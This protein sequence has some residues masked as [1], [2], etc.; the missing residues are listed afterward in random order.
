MDDKK[1]HH[2]RI[3]SV[4][5]AMNPELLKDLQCFFCGGTAIALQL[6]DFRKSV[7]IDFVCS[8][9][10]GYRELRGLVGQYS[11]TGLSALFDRPVPQLREV[12]AD[13]YGIRSVLDVGGVPVKFEV[14]RE[15]RISLDASFEQLH[16]VPLIARA[17]AYAHKLLANSD[18]WGDRSVLSRDIIDLA[19]MVRSWGHVPL[20]AEQ[21]VREAYGDAPTKD[22]VLAAGRVVDDE[23]YRKNCFTKHPHK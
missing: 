2:H 7:D 4:L 15:D 16:G 21:K 13:R 17:D 22:F 19:V 20:A 5:E 23:R 3:V 6:N 11:M 9:V 18:R 14:I 1:A 8:G 12:R 10:D